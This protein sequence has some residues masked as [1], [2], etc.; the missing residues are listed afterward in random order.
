MTEI[1]QLTDLYCQVIDM[2]STSKLTKQSSPL[3]VTQ[4]LL[5]KYV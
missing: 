1:W 5:K 3:T 4:L 2:K